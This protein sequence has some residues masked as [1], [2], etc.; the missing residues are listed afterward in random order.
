MRTLTLHHHGQ[1]AALSGVLV[2]VN[3][4]SEEPCALCGGPLHVQKTTARN[5]R[6]LAHGHFI[7]NET[8]Y[9]CPAC[10]S[11][12]TNQR[13]FVKR[14]EELQAL[15]LPR[16]SIGYDVM[17]F[18][19]TERFI[20]H[21]QREE[22][23]S[24]LKRQYGIDLSTGKISDLE[25]TFTHY[26]KALHESK[27]PQIKAAL[28]S[29]FP[30][31][32]DA[33]CETGRGTL[34]VAYCGDPEW[35][36]GAWKIP[37]ERADAILPRLRAI[38]TLFGA[39]CSIMRDLGRAVTDAALEFVGD[40]QIQILACHLHFLKDIGKDLLT[41]AHDK[42]REF[43][44]RHKI[45]A[46]LASHAR[47][48]GRS[49]GQDIDKTQDMINV[50]LKSERHQALPTGARG[51]AVV[52]AVTQWVLDF[53]DDGSD[54]G[55]PFDCPM[56]DLYNRCR[57][58]LRVVESLLQHPSEQKEVNRALVV[59]H[60]ILLPVRGQ[61]P[62]DSWARSLDAR[63]KL[64]Q[65]LRNVL[66]VDVKPKA[67]AALQKSERE[68]EVNE[69]QNAQKALASFEASLR[70]NRP[71][72]GP[73]KDLREATDIIL[74]HLQR[75]GPNLWGHSI[76]RSDGTT[77]LV[78]RTNVMLERLFGKSKRRERRRSGRKNLT[79]DLEQLPAEAFL[80]LNL[81]SQAYLDIGCGGK[82]EN[83][84][85][86]FAKLDE[87]NRS[88][89][90]PTRLQAKELAG[91]EARDIVSSSLPRADR[92]LVRTKAWT[93]RLSVEALSRAPLRQDTRKQRSPTVD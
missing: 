18:C 55:F 23:Q 59:L 13:P 65:K 32:I 19:G 27:A 74:K 2:H 72:R 3:V 15:I 21:R 58:A 45:R 89:S 28:E 25:R 39:P 42:L 22:I 85:A 70:K 26:F 29:G 78:A 64:F 7:V 69:L 82:I 91:E 57:Q 24:D 77:I 34:L 88:Q 92:V 53:A 9:F 87:G 60:R 33:T 36:L 68:H 62:F 31:H 12:E 83:L 48:L 40:R 54:A 37:T 30:L 76:E 86:E 17:A 75:H 35:V 43:F 49:I 52:R 71:E 46:R 56:W 4:F 38:E 50:W 1:L 14:Q 73:A 93:D 5:G 8:V 44:R 11:A 47:T 79:Q 90:L 81:E 20:K 41:P 63:A 66:R 6:T 67:G 16:S 84:A 10:K 61:I 80:A 51:L